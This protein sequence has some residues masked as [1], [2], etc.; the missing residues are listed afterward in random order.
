MRIWL[1]AGIALV[2]FLAGCGDDSSLKTDA[3]LGLN[4]QQA[5]G[6]QL[7]RQSCAPCHDA[8]SVPG[9]NG[10]N[11]KGLLKKQFLP[12]GLPA[13]ERFV[14]QTILNGRNMMPAVGGTLTPQELDDLLA[15]LHT[16]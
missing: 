10:P 5:A 4:S 15:Y 12:S 6:R 13:N 8:H 11:L 9:E 7:Y 3:Q 14:R 2:A 16:L 1:L